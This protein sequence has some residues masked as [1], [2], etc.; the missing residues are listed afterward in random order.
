MIGRRIGIIEEQ[1]FYC[2]KRHEAQQDSTVILLMK[3]RKDKKNL[4]LSFFI[5][6]F[7]HAKFGDVNYDN[8]EDCD[9]I[10]EA[11]Q[12]LSVFIYFSDFSQ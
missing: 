8:K 12:V 2:E 10:V 5:Y 11:P 6:Y 4:G 3:K 7:S 9:W 1:F